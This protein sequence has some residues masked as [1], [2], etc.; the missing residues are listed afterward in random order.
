MIKQ[1]AVVAG[2]AREF[3]SY[4]QEF[5]FARSE[6]SIT[7]RNEFTIGDERHFYVT[8]SKRLLGV[9][10][11]DIIYYGTW[12]KRDDLKEISDEAA[13]RLPDRN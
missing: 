11:E 10:L 6:P 13:F 3:E 4:R 2:S 12:V 9:R 7:Q 5:L 8:D 1:I